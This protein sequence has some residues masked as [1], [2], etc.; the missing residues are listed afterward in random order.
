MM[1]LGAGA[2]LIGAALLYHFVTSGEESNEVEVPEVSHDELVESL[3]KENLL[4]VP[5]RQNGQI[6]TN[7]FLRLLQFV[8]KTT[9]EMTAEKRKYLTAERRAVYNK[10]EAAY[11]AIV[12]QT[13]E[14]EDQ[15]A[16][17]ILR[18]ILE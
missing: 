8:G 3:K 10:D 7:Y 13:I 17:K 14:L 2:A 4:E 15:A 5:P 1:A 16:Q 11:G 9:R 18:E 12:K 6:D